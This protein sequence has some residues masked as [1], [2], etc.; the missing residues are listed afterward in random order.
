M[1]KSIFMDKYPIYSLEL[2]KDEISQKSIQDIINYFLDKIEKHPIATNI[3]V[4]NHYEH[5]K[6]LNGPIND[7]IIDAQNVIFCF[8]AAIPNSKILAVRPRSIGIA[9]FKEKFSIEFLEAPNEKLHDVMEEW[10]V[11]L[12]K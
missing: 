2:N 4:F 12:K 6:K 10:T 3:A 8:G 5:T 9:E 7:E 1:K 11:D